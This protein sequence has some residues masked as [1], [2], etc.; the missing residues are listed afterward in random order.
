[1]NQKPWEKEQSRY[2][3]QGQQQPNKPNLRYYLSHKTSK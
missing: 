1:M 2:N 3:L